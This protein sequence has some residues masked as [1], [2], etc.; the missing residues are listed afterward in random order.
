MALLAAI[1]VVT[2]TVLVSVT[3]RTREIG[4][5]RALGARRNQIVQEVLAE[6][7][8]AARLAAASAGATAAVLLIGGG[9]GPMLPIP[10]D[11]A[12]RRRW[13]WHLTA[14]AGSGV[15]AGWY[16]AV[17][18]TRLDVIAALRSE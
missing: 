12:R 8:V 4:I 10:A 2:N 14:A 11:R 3:Q 5:R 9:L 17:R 1:V 13:R 7:G 6:V 16:P 15:A 18:A